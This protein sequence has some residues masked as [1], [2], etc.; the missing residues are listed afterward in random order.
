M[1]RH[2]WCFFFNSKLLK[3]LK[4]NFLKNN[5]SESRKAQKAMDKPSLMGPGTLR[6][7]GVVQNAGSQE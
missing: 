4:V 2:F 5:L 7:R 1:F 6:N 3:L